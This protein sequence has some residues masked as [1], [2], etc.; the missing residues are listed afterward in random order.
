MYPSVLQFWV[1]LWVALLLTRRGFGSIFVRLGARFLLWSLVP[2]GLSLL[3]V[4][5]PGV[6]LAPIEL[7]FCL[8][9]GR[10]GVALL[11]LLCSPPFCGPLGPLFGLWLL[12]LPWVAP[13][14][15]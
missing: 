4:L 9:S 12:L 13:G 10:F 15:A 14:R 8:G 1:A 5:R 6:P 11:W 7:H 2:W 3:P